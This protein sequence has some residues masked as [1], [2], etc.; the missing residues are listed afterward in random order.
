MRNRIGLSMVLVHL[1]LKGAFTSVSLTSSTT[2][3]R[4]N[5]IS[6]LANRN[7]FGIIQILNIHRSWARTK[8]QSCIHDSIIVELWLHEGVLLVWILEGFHFLE[9]AEFL[10]L[11]FYRWCPKLFAFVV[12]LVET[13]FNMFW[14]GRTRIANF[15]ISTRSTFRAFSFDTCWAAAFTALAFEKM[16]CCR[17]VEVAQRA[18]I[19]V[20]HL[21]NFPRLLHFHCQLGLLELI[22]VFP[23]GLAVEDLEVL[24]LFVLVK[25]L[26]S[27]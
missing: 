12:L 20:R 18:S 1:L 6:I 16:L 26:E 24:Q 22:W 19:P 11:A 13:S 5:I 23:W 27:L 4:S 15:D 7:T 21:V 17:E 25:R 8:H 2:N 10:L 14:I 3:L 9:L